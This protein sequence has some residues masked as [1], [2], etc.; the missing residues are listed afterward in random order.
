[1][2]THLNKNS[3]INLV[4]LIVSIIFALF[5]IELSL[6]IFNYSYAP[7]KIEKMNKIEGYGR[8]DQ[9]PFNENK[10]E[11]FIADPYLIWR[12][13]KDFRNFFNSQGFRG[14]LLNKD[15]DSKDFY[16]FT[17]GDS[18]TLGPRDDLGWVEYLGRALEEKYN[19]I[20]VV[21]AGAWGYSSFQCLRRFK[22][23][24]KYNPDLVIFSCCSNDARQVSISDAKYAAAKRYLRSW[25]RNLRIMHVLFALSD[26][27]LFKEN[28]K[29]VAR[30]SLEEY[31][32]NLNEVISLADKNNVTLILLSRPFIGLPDYPL[33]YRNFFSPYN[34]LTKDTANSKNLSL[35][36]FHL[37]FRNKTEYFQDS[38]HFN[39]KGHQVA[40]KIIMERI[41][42]YINK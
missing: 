11:Y 25:I 6:R 33:D 16:I 5:I 32:G 42:N 40:S 8:L 37:H 20:K 3:T 12:P 4:V 28:N 23:T 35:V 41:K 21:N 22:E 27:I 1:M 18:N 10:E 15:K 34:K 7:L 30:V 17:I 13:K 19:D 26:I 39:K 9:R 14:P 24:L 38:C 2:K 29:L 31:T 36:D